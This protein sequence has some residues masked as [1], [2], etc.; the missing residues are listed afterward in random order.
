MC[1]DVEIA[2]VSMHSVSSVVRSWYLQLALIVSVAVLHCYSGCCH[3]CQ[4]PQAPQLFG[5]S[6]Q[7]PGITHISTSSSSSNHCYSMNLQA[8]LCKLS[9]H[10]SLCI[11][12]NHLDASAKAWL[13]GFLGRYSGTVVTVTHDEGEFSVHIAVRHGVVESLHTCAV[14]YIKV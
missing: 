11:Q 3:Q 12:T 6:L 4:L 9:P 8:N 2:V 14:C 13:A 1:R 7:C 10:A 5:C